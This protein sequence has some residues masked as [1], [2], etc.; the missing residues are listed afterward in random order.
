MPG[1]NI[2]QGKYMNDWG[3][4]GDGSLP[5]SGGLDSKITMLKITE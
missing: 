4:D 5:R 3:L 2:R 1:K